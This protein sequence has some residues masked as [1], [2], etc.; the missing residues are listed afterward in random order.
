MASIYQYISP[1]IP[2]GIFYLCSQWQGI[3]FIHSLLESAFHQQLK[4]VN[5][6]A[7]P[8]VKQIQ[9]QMIK[10]TD[11]IRYA[12]NVAHLGLVFLYA[13][14]LD[15][16]LP[17]LFFKNFQ[18]HSAV[19]NKSLRIFGISIVAIIAA[20][21]ITGVAQYVYA[22][23]KYS[24]ETY[25]EEE[26]PDITI[27][28]KIDFQQQ[29]ALSLHLTTLVFNISLFYFSNSRF[30][31]GI[32][33]LGSVYSLWQNLIKRH[34]LNVSQPSTFHAENDDFSMELSLSTMKLPPPASF[35]DTCSICLDPKSDQKKTTYCLS[36]V[37]HARCISQDISSKILDTIDPTQI[38]TYLK[39]G[40]LTGY[41]LKVST[42]HLPTCPNC[43]QNPPLTR[44][45]VQVN[46]LP[47]ALENLDQPTIDYQ[48]RFEVFYT[49]YNVVQVILSHL[50]KYPE[51]AATI[52]KIQEVLLI[53]DF[54]GYGLTL[55]FSATQLVKNVKKDDPERTKKIAY[56][57]IALTV[58]TLALA[59]FSY[60]A[61]LKFNAY[62]K[63]SSTLN[64]ILKQ[65]S[66]F[67]EGTNM[68]WSSPWT[69]HPMQ[70]LQINQIVASLFS[71]YFCPKRKGLHVAN[72]LL[73]SFSFFTTS[74]LKWIQ[75][76]Q[77]LRQ[78]LE[79]IV[80]TGGSLDEHLQTA[81]LKKLSV[82][83][84]FMVPASCSGEQT[85]LPS[86][87]QS[88][89]RY[90]NTLL[91]GS[92]WRRFIGIDN[93]SRQ[94]WANIVKADKKMLDAYQDLWKIQRELGE[95]LTKTTKNPYTMIYKVQL[96]AHRLFSC[97]CGLSSE[98]THIYFDATDWSSKNSCVILS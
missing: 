67:R 82:N 78:P 71:A 7:H 48:R 14:K 36:H 90:G 72:A 1:T 70:C 60:F 54:L 63:P 92:N 68:E 88:I 76:T 44:L 66:I 77:F 25:Q 55:F 19:S 2:K 13:A 5:L 42:I 15:K 74:Q 57:L 98:L 97:A 33:L 83:A 59:A 32:N 69:H 53:T 84:Y 35:D 31:L 39:N 22:N 41:G 24:V 37:F 49:T 18:T 8:K 30:W 87:V 56:R 17:S 58:G 52:F 61:M 21:A 16:H 20:A 80:E 73:R 38:T 6:K 9:E 10:H 51:L 89:Y 50:Q 29:L 81:Y 46:G 4:G 26:L 79:A 34:W 93:L 65:L 91:D 85:H 86:V 94:G 28:K 27:K 64:Q 11:D 23:S 12:F 40:R 62:L 96:N 75:Y 47:T 95:P 43:R 3:S 45:D